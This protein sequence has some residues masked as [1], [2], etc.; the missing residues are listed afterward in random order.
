MEALFDERKKD[1]LLINGQS[2][3][4]FIVMIEEGSVEVLVKCGSLCILV[5]LTYVTPRIQNRSKTS[6]PEK[7]TGASMVSIDGP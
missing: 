4:L 5:S 1:C 3:S 7:S 6:F 2:P